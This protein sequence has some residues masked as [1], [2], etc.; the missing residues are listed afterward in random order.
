MRCFPVSLQCTVLRGVICMC[1]LLLLTSILIEFR[2]TFLHS[3]K[4]PIDLMPRASLSNRHQLAFGEPTQGENKLWAL[5]PKP[6]PSSA[7]THSECVFIPQFQCDGDSWRPVWPH[8]GCEIEAGVPHRAVV[9]VLCRCRQHTT[10]HVRCWHDHRF[11]VG[12][13]RQRRPDQKGTNWP[14]SQS[15]LLTHCH[16]TYGATRSC[17]V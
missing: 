12:S 5:S 6:W 15:H 10:P 2:F 1:L 11:V 14:F 17:A 9:I 4:P 3:L 7:A 13:T 16:C 8:G